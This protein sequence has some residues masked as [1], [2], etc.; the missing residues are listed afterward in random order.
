M[1]KDALQSLSNVE[2]FAI[3]SLVLFLISFLV[4]LIYIM[5]IKK[6]DVIRYSRLPLDESDAIRPVTVPVENKT[7]K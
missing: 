2:M 6:E 4:V 5:K 7:G 1:I 3:I